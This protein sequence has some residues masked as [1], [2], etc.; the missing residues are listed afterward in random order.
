MKSDDD[1]GASRHNILSAPASIGMLN[2]DG[3][4]AMMQRTVL[5]TLK[6]FDLENH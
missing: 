5:N 3:S 6:L 4:S 1:H 2:T